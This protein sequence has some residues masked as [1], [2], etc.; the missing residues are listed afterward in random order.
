[1]AL[2]DRIVDAL[3]SAAF[4]YEQLAG[5]LGLMRQ[6]INKTCRV[7]EKRGVLV[8]AIGSGGKR[9]RRSF[10]PATAARPT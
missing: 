4:D 7:L 8:R 9:S 1:M 3:G 6:Q 5:Q 10:T 2:R